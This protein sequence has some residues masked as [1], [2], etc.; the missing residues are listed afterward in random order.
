MSDKKFKIIDTIVNV[1]VS[2]ILAIVLIYSLVIL[3]DDPNTSD[4]V[5]TVIFIVGTFG[6]ALLL[7]IVVS[8]DVASRHD[9]IS[10]N[11][12]NLL[13]DKFTNY[14]IMNVYGKECKDD[15]D[16]REFYVLA[17]DVIYKCKYTS[18]SD[19]LY[20]QEVPALPVVLKSKEKNKRRSY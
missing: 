11:V 3:P 6:I 7:D 14:R 9:T 19:E 5:F 15:I 16:F 20:M 1:V 12:I 10:T 17:D 4:K 13:N 2:L 18:E 8:K